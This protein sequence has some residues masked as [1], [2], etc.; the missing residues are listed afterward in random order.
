MP[1]SLG[2]ALLTGS[3]LWIGLARVL[4]VFY[5]LRSREEERLLAEGDP[6]YRTRV[7]HINR[8]VPH[9]Y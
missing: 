4:T 9:L 5:D 8:F 6:A 1:G 2:G 3:P 7:R